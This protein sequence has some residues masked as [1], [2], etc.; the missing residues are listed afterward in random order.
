MAAG[1][2]VAAGA[3]AAEQAGK[4]ASGG[5]AAASLEAPDGSPLLLALRAGET[6]RSAVGRRLRRRHGSAKLLR[7]QRGVR[8]QGGGCARRLGS[9]APDGRGVVFQRP[10]QQLQRALLCH[11]LS[12]RRVGLAR[13]VRELP[14]QLLHLLQRL[15][16][17]VTVLSRRLLGSAGA[18][19]AVTVGIASCCCCYC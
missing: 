11:E 18:T 5:A 16:E 9:N 14:L 13:Q 4:A 8:A 19:A 12:E 17:L 15:R 6:R 7:A 10:L 3:Q 1:A 2:L